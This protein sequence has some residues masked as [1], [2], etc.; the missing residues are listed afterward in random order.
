[1]LAGG[2]SK[3]HVDFNRVVSN[4]F[5]HSWMGYISE[6]QAPS[7]VLLTTDV[8]YFYSQSLFSAI[9]AGNFNLTLC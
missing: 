3:R 7:L 6:E 9:Q 2:L 8:I 4:I 1:M 5:G